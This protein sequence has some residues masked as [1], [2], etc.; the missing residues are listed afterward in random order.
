LDDSDVQLFLAWRFDHPDRFQFD[1]ENARIQ[2]IVTAMTTKTFITAIISFALPSL[3]YGLD[4]GA[5]LVTPSVRRYEL[6]LKDLKHLLQ[7][8]SEPSLSFILS[9]QFAD[10]VQIHQYLVR[11]TL[12]AAL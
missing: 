5:A 3:I 4:S 8:L 9:A 6:I 7:H 10:H 2:R 12:E 11:T 1:L